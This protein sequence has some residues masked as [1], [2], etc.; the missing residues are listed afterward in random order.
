MTINCFFV[1]LCNAVFLLIFLHS[2]LAFGFPG[3]GLLTSNSFL[4]EI[5]RLSREALQNTETRT[6]ISEIVEPKTGLQWSSK[7]TRRWSLIEP[8]NDVKKHPWIVCKKDNYLMFGLKETSESETIRFAVRSRDGF[9]L[10]MRNYT[11]CDIDL[12]RTDHRYFEAQHQ[13]HEYY[14]LLKHVISQDYLRLNEETQSI[15]FTNNEFATLWWIR[16]VRSG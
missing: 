12:N 4:E 9:R 5:V 8:I 14:V 16:Y 1:H 7:R 15:D 2:K 13:P 6:L 11:N 3:H 10:S